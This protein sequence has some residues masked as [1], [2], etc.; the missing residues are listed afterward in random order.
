M[1]FLHLDPAFDQLQSTAPQNTGNRIINAS[2][3]IV[4][5]CILQPSLWC[6]QL[7]LSLQG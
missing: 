5:Q 7:S 4:I 1:K 2:I 6:L 3:S